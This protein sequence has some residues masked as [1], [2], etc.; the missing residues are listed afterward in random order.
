MKTLYISNQDLTA[1]K[2]STFLSADVSS[3]SSTLTVESIVG[4]AIDQ[5]LC[6]GEIG[7]ENSEIVHTHAATSPTGTTITLSAALTFSHNR[8]TKVYII[9]FD[10]I[11]VSWSAT[12]TGTKTVLA[13]IEV[14]S[15][16]LETIYNDSTETT[17]YYFSRFVNSIPTPDTYS[18][19]S[20]PVS[21]SGYADN[22]VWAIKNR[23]L[24]DLGEVV[25]G[26][27]I[28]DSWL[29]DALWEGRRSL[30]NDKQITKWSFRIK[31]NANIGSIIPGIYTLA[32]PS[33][34][35]KP[36]TSEHILSLRVG[37]RGQP[38]SYQDINDFNENYEGVVHTTLNGALLTGDTSIVLTDSGDFDET[39]DIKIAAVSVATTID[40][41]TYT[42]NTEATNTLTGVTGIQAAG[43]TTGRDVWQH[44]NF[45]LPNTYTVD[46]ENKQLE[47]DVPFDD[48]YA[49][50]N[51]YMDYYT[52]LPA[53]DSDTDVLDEPEYDLFVSWLKWK[54]KY[55]LSGGKLKQ[56]EDP[57][58]AEW[59]KG[60]DDLI[61]KERLGQ[62]VSFTL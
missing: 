30:D 61:T 52:V 39:G 8:G 5:N 43:H 46:G 37:E 17:G 6:I 41:V 45:G 20:D 53:Y 55:K 13:T 57:D 28:S 10:Q 31:R 15:D 48:D 11:E 3:G 49:G 29:N 34:L 18:D 32:L 62:D 51:I 16:Q 50:E 4:Y 7:E 40:T 60:K 27:T 23:A 33:D 25:D 26:K 56:K 12:T 36:N 47:F 22:T 54:I 9:D 21:Y 19:Y 2:K 35:R 24:N 14:Q 44:C 58:Y 59:L 1:E 42:G 38:L